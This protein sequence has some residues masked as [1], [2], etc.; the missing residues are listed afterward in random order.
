MPAQESTGNRPTP[1]SR[2]SG[3]RVRCGAGIAVL[4]LMLVS[5]LAMPA[6]A[7]V[8]VFVG[9]VIGLPGYS[10]PYPYGSYVYPPYPHY[11]PYPV[12]GGAPPCGWVRGHWVWRHDA[13]GRRV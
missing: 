11:A 5:I 13:G 12:S 10:Y 6:S 7:H 4:V 2:P 9:G 8:R 1:R 3:G